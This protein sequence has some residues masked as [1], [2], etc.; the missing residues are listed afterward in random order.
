VTVLDVA[1]I[2]VRKGTAAQWALANPVLGQGEWGLE[3][4]TKF[5]KIGDGVTTWGSLTYSLAGAITSAQ[6]AAIV[7][8]ETGSGSLVFAN[9]PALT[10]APTAPTASVNTNTSQI[11]TTAFVLANAGSGASDQIILATQI[12]G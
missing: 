7:S 2:N 10:G 9:S 3:T 4:D 12:F 5:L 11:A 6:I 1:Q 8:D